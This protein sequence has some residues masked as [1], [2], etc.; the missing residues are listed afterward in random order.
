MPSSWTCS[1]S[2]QMSTGKWVASSGQNRSSIKSWAS[3]NIC[4]AGC[5]SFSPNTFRRTR[6]HRLS[7]S[8][9]RVDKLSKQS[10]CLLFWLLLLLLS[11]QLRRAEVN[12]VG[13]RVPLHNVLSMTSSELTW[14][15]L[16]EANDLVVH[17]RTSTWF[18]W[19]ISST[20]KK[21]FRDNNGSPT[22]M[23]TWRIC[24]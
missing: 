11:S 23:R 21:G 4:P 19:S 14:H 18:T 24:L 10:S 7:L 9:S 17:V 6:R 5:H 20:W 3:I 13:C 1:S 16:A 12:D 8:S 22:V 15:Y 2:V